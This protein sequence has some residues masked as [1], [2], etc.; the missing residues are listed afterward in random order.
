MSTTY[1]PSNTDPWA[2]ICGPGPR[3]CYKCLCWY[4]PE[5]QP[6]KCFQP[7]V[8]EYNED[9]TIKRIEYFERTA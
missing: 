1:A 2:S 8:I 4:K 9:G 5:E 7:K 3:L 6:H